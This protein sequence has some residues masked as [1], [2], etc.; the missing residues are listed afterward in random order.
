MSTVICGPQDANA[1]NILHDNTYQLSSA[2][3]FWVSG[4]ASVL[5]R[6]CSVWTEEVVMLGERKDAQNVLGFDQ[7]AIATSSHSFT[8]NS[9]LALLLAHI[10][11]FH[12]QTHLASLLQSEL[13]NLVCYWHSNVSQCITRYNPQKSQLNCIVQKSYILEW[14]QTFEVHYSISKW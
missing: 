4:P 13:F 8:Y 2:C 14:P 1:D 7:S 11:H 12:L 9:S 10:L 6:S 3:N 5:T